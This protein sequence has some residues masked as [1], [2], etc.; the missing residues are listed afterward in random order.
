MILSPNIKILK[1]ENESEDE[2]EVTLGNGNHTAVFNGK[3]LEG[4]RIHKEEPIA[5]IQDLAAAV[6][7]QNITWDAGQQEAYVL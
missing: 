5:W 6:G 3:T 7:A 1:E 2:N 4:I